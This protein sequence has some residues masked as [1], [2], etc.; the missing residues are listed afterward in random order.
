MM[1]EV[2]TLNVQIFLVAGFRVP[3]EVA[4]FYVG[5]LHILTAAEVTRSP[6]ISRIR[7]EI[8]LNIRYRDE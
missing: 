2:M 3:Y 4:H 8:P 7:G 5:N 1:A 6:K